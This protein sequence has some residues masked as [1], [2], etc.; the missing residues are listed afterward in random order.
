MKFSRVYIE[1]I[2]YELAPVVVSTAELEARLEPLFQSLH[3]QSG[4]IEALTGITER[5]WW[6]ADFALS[7]GAALAARKALDLSNIS[8]DEIDI[9]IYAGVCREQFEPATACRVA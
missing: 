9:L 3:L 1:S 8:T 4:Q 7:R 6:G 2:G 5:R